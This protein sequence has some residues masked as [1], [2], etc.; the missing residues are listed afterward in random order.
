MIGWSTMNERLPDD[1]TLNRIL[2][3]SV[4]PKGG[5]HRQIYNN[6]LLLI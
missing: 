2:D 4:Q 5:K 1:M 6:N 3:V